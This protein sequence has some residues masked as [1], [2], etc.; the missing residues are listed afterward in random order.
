MKEQID[1][2]RKVRAEFIKIMTP[3]SIEQLNHIPL[4]YNNNILWN[5]GHIIVVQQALC[6][7]LAGLP[8]NVDKA[9]S[10]KYRKG[11]KP[12]SVISIEEF[13][14]L[15]N[16]SVSLLDI[17]DKDLKK[18]STFKNMKPYMTSLGFE[19]DKIEKAIQFNTFHEGLHYG[20]A[21]SLK[22]VVVASALAE[23]V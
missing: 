19:I 12:E 15:K 18:K 23:P 2:I 22:R 4:G 16:L 7:A 10:E 14:M 20:Y 1:I 9:L 8:Q 11:T 3:L 17:F 21:M 6:Y 5:F 13:E